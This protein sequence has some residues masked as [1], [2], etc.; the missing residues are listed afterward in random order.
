MADDHNPL[1]K[2]YLA[3]PAGGEAAR[4]SIEPPDRQDNII[5]QTRSAPPTEY[6]NRL[7]DALIVCFKAGIEELDPLVRRLND[8]GVKAPDGTDW[9]SENFA[10]VLDLM[11]A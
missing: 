5:W 4:G 8:M 6:E 3:V 10:A 2:G 9:T 1:L 7:A 11:G